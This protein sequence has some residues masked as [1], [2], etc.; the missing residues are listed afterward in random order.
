MKVKAYFEFITEL[1]KRYG[2]RPEM[3][4]EEFEKFAGCSQPKKLWWHLKQF[5][6]ITNKDCH[7]FYGIRHCPAVIRDLKDNLKYFGAGDAQIVSVEK[8]GVDRWGNKTPFVE[9]TLCAA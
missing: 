7:E 1:E 5:G 6:F 4:F 9:Y 2:K 8:S 3:T